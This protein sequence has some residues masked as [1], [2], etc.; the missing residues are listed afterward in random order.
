MR[1]KVSYVAVAVLGGA[2][3][4][5]VGCGLLSKDL[6]RTSF[7]LPPKSFAFDTSAWHLPSGDLP[8]VPCGD[9]QLVTDCCSL[10]PPAPDCSVNMITCDNALCTLHVPLSLAQSV[11]LKM[12]VPALSSFSNQSLINVTISKISY[13]YASTLN[14]DLPPMDLYIANDG[15]TTAPGDGAQKFG[16]T[17]TIHANGSGTDDVALDPSGASAFADHAHHFGTPFNFI[18]TTT[19]VIPSGSPIPSGSVTV[20]VQGT[21]TASL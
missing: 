4:S 17:K 9:G 6:L 21:A 12:E 19:V 18:A 7:N 1:F 10:P 8:A 2:M 14:V 15:V 3:A 16:T 20:T 5:A 13:T 11:N